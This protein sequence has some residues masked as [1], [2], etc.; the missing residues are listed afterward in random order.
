LGKRK[1]N[2]ASFWFVLGLRG[3]ENFGWR[4]GKRQL[5]EGSSQG[6]RQLGK[7]KEEN[8]FGL[9]SVRSGEMSGEIKERGRS[10][11]RK[12][13]ARGAAALVLKEIGLGL[14]FS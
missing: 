7:K 1:G 4:E 8:G 6:R 13:Q 12:S 2:W 3:R 11:E 10:S 14:G 9:G 5:K